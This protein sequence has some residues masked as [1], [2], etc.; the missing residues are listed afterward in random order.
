MLG[1]QTH[2]ATANK[3]GF[4][5]PLW[6]ARVR[7]IRHLPLA[8]TKSP[9]RLA[10]MI[11]KVSILWIQEELTVKHLGRLSGPL[12]IVSFVHV[13]LRKLLTASSIQSLIQ[14]KWPKCLTSIPTESRGHQND[15]CHRPCYK[16]QSGSCKFSDS[17]CQYSHTPLPPMAPPSIRQHPYR[18]HIRHQ[19]PISLGCSHGNG[20]QGQEFPTGPHSDSY[21]A[22]GTYG[23]MWNARYSNQPSVNLQ[24]CGFPLSG[25]SRQNWGSHRNTYRGGRFI[26]QNNN[27]YSRQ[28]PGGARPNGRAQN[29][30][31][32]YTA[33]GPSGR[34]NSI[35]SSVSVRH[36]RVIQ[37]IIAYLTVLESVDLDPR[38]L[39]SSPSI[40]M[41]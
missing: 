20:Y 15:R 37:R 10:Q 33:Q 28:V 9:C 30:Q 23:L 25:G 27:V 26:Q 1:S 41:Q 14:D 35:D 12:A 13:S 18:N 24:Q 3:T 2:S 39:L 11:V 22:G 7:P 6:S 4:D 5:H 34:R 36:T 29:K 31:A 19:T 32:L 17:T 16:F 21:A 38:Y 40:H 8:I